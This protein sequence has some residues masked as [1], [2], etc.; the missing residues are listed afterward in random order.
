MQRKTIEILL[1]Y[2]VVH[3]IRLLNYVNRWHDYFTYTHII[4]HNTYK[5]AYKI[6]ITCNNSFYLLICRMNEFI[7]YF[8]TNAAKKRALVGLITYTK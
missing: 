2:F 4:Y 7:L 6:K 8:V 5:F 1:N 3:T